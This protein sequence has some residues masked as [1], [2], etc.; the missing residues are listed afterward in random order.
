MNVCIK[1]GKHS[2]PIPKGAAEMIAEFLAEKGFDYKVTAM[3]G[4]RV[5]GAPHLKGARVVKIASVRGVQLRVQP[6]DND[7]AYMYVV[8]APAGMTGSEFY[9]RLVSTGR[10]EES[11]NESE[12]GDSNQQSLPVFQLLSVGQLFAI[13]QGIAALEVMAAADEA[14]AL[15]ER[16]EQHIASQIQQIDQLTGSVRALQ[17]KLEI[18]EGDLSAA[19]DELLPIKNERAK[20]LAQLKAADEQ[21]A[22]VEAKKRGLKSDRNRLVKD[23]SHAKDAG[24]EL[25]A[26]L[27]R[28]RSIQSINFSAIRGISDEILRMI[29]EEYDE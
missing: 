18:I 12:K 1:I 11:T 16:M 8:P 19:E 7:T 17:K 20:L 29:N 24:H 9:D 5:Y 2:T 23:L 26:E 4:Q 3:L 22:N 25:V 10:S 27:R 15:D 28:L 6:G 14:M 21:I 13:N